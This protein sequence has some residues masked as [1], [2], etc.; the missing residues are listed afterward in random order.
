MI[1]TPST[2]SAALTLD[3]KGRAVLPASVRRAAGV[4]EESTLVAWVAA[5]G[6]IVIETPEAVQARV[7][8]A[9][10]AA[11]DLNA[12]AAIREVRVED[13][14][15]SDENFARRAAAGDSDSDAVGAALLADL[16]L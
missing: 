14:R 11:G 13:A 1:I 15:N 9:A 2:V 12:T 6:T 8:A 4:D 16:R 10:S 7:W 3:R 5:E